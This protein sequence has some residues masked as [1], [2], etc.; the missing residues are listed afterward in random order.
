M[1]TDRAANLGENPEQPRRWAPELTECAERPAF[2]GGPPKPDND[3]PLEGAGL[4]LCGQP[5][6]LHQIGGGPCFS[7]GC[8]EY[9]PAIIDGETGELRPDTPAIRVEYDAGEDPQ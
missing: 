5:E 2:T 7:S 1:T 6:D 4:C 3:P 8:E 9:R